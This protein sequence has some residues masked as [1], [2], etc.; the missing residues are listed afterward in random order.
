MTVP[1]VP[2]FPERGLPYVVRWR[3]NGRRYWR[4][5]ATKRGNNGADTFCSLLTVAAMNER[6][7]SSETGLPTTWDSKSEMNI[8]EYCR[9]YIQDEWKRLSPSTRKSY[10]EALTSFTINCAR[11]GV[12][13][14]PTLGRNAIGSWLTPTLTTA[15]SSFRST[16]VWSDEPL[17]RSV[18]NWVARH[19]PSLGDLDRELLH[20]TVRRIYTT[21][22]NVNKLLR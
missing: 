19:S 16:R 11:R 14:L 21:S 18:Q 3:V 13:T 1:Q 5:F 17:A 20:E 9:L 7:W 15:N 2:E 10:V 22:V 8:A 4:S 6:D 12:P